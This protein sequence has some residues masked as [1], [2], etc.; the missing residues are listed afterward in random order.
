M[1]STPPRRCSPAWGPSTRTQHGQASLL[2]F[3]LPP[4]DCA[5]G[6]SPS[7]PSPPLHAPVILPPM[8]VQQDAGGK[9]AGLGERMR[10]TRAHAQRASCPWQTWVW[11]WAGGW[12][13]IMRGPCRHRGP[14]RA[15]WVLALSKYCGRRSLTGAHAQRGFLGRVELAARL[16][17]TCLELSSKGPRPCWE[18]AGLHARDMTSSPGQ[19]WGS[20]ALAA[21]AAALASSAVTALCVR[22]ACM[23]RRSGSCHGEECSLAG[24]EECGDRGANG[25]ATRTDPYS[26]APRAG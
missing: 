18:R 11:D 2:S 20:V 5:F 4:P 3:I 19:H 7:L 21:G 13:W 1:N 8:S 23:A 25:I 12:G 9:G 14:A 16:L 17:S 10:A 24:G 15:C 26:A 6:L 22:R